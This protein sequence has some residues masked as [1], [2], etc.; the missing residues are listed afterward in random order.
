MIYT[1]FV[2]IFHQHINLYLSDIMSK[3]DVIRAWNGMII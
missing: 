2:H 1:L 3:F